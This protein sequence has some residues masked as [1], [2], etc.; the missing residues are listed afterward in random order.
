M[1]IDGCFFISCY[2]IYLFNAY[3]STEASE[4]FSEEKKR[5]CPEVNVDASV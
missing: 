4:L 5:K 3:T 2:S 1:R